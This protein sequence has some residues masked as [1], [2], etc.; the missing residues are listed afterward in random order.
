M[1][2]IDRHRWVWLSTYT[3]VY[4]MFAFLYRASHE[5]RIIIII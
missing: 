4:V 3:Y 1:M 5:R 2:S